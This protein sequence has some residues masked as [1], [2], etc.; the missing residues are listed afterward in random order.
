[1][2]NVLID[3]FMLIC[4]VTFLCLIII[5]KIKGTQIENSIFL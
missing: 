5:G 3:T 4:H 1:M 2:F